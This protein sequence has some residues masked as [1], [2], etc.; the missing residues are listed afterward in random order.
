MDGYDSIQQKIL[1]GGNRMKKGLIV[2]A[3]A[4]MLAVLLAAPAAAQNVG[5]QEG[6][7]KDVE[8]NPLEGIKVNF[9]RLDSTGSGTD[10]MS[11]VT[12]AN[13]EFNVRYIGSSGKW[14]VSIMEEGYMPYQKMIEISVLDA[15]P[16]LEIVLQPGTPLAAENAQEEAKKVIKAA[17]ALQAEGKYDEAIQK[18]EELAE[19]FPTTEGTV[20]LYIG[21]AY[22]NK[23]EMDKAKEAY[24]KALENDPNSAIALKKLGDMAVK[25][26]EYEPAMEYY[27]RLLAIKT[28][29][30]A[31][32][33]TAGEIALSVGNNEKAIEYFKTYVENGTDAGTLVNAHMNL[34]FTLS[35]LGKNEEAIT[36]L[37][38]V[39]EMAPD[40]PYAGEIKAEIDRLKSL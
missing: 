5:R 10:N 35:V 28:D 3:F 2:T 25:A 17:E 15:N 33:Y 11:A 19:K 13:G 23:G 27:D 14:K 4:V 1:I 29:E 24:E 31:L 40:F 22:E 8:G 36:H 12:D 7:V 20:A 18:F 9:D 21:Q 6:V 26:Y 39:L 37:E 30:P 32:Y 16:D 34:G 38:K